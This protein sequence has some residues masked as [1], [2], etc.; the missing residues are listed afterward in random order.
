MTATSRWINALPYDLSYPM[1]DVRCLSMP[2]KLC[3]TLSLPIT[4]ANVHHAQ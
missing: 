4:L 1:M 3:L 2:S